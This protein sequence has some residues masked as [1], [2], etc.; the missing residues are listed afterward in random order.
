METLPMDVAIA[1]SPEDIHS[2]T[3]RD[4]L[5]DI[6]TVGAEQNVRWSYWDVSIAERTVS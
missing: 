2:V 3:D 6:A 5:E 4:E 1:C